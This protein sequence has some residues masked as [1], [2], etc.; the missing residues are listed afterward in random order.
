MLFADFSPERFWELCRGRAAASATLCATY[1]AAAAKGC[2]SE[3]E[4]GDSAAAATAAFAVRCRKIAL[5]QLRKCLEK[6]GGCLHIYII[7]RCRNLL[8]LFLL[9]LLLHL[10]LWI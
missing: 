6:L 5:W 2:S 10:L 1:F 9:L 8:L 3:T 4:E 7:E